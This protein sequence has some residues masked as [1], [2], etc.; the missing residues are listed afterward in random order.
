MVRAFCQ[1]VFS[2]SKSHIFLYYVY[3]KYLSY[4]KTRRKFRQKALGFYTNKAWFS[5]SVYVKSQNT[6]ILCDNLMLIYKL[7]LRD[8]TI[9]CALK[10]L[11]LLVVRRDTQFLAPFLMACPMTT[12]PMPFCS[13]R[14]QELSQQTVL[15]LV[16]REFC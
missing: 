12:E 11:G 13:K 7:S 2:K 1:S 9:L 4:K 15:C 14:E 10:P 8:T 16:Y 5:L 6:A 3:S